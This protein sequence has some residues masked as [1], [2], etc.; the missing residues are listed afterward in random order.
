MGLRA[1]RDLRTTV[2]D[3][4]SCLETWTS[5]LARPER[6]N[7]RW[8]EAYTTGRRGGAAQRPYRQ[9][10]RDSVLVEW[11]GIHGMAILLVCLRSSEWRWKAKGRKQ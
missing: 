4:K 1:R 11:V 9:G 6:G 2:A 5:F 10:F 3:S 8:W 7:R